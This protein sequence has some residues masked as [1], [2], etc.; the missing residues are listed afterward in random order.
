MAHHVHRFA[1]LGEPVLIIENW[2]Q[3]YEG[4]GNGHLSGRDRIEAAYTGATVERVWLT[5]SVVSYLRNRRD[6]GFARADGEARATQEAPEGTAALDQPAICAF[7]T[8]RIVCATAA[9]DVA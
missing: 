4:P 9:S 7:R 8:R 5:I 1:R 6:L 3:A 2:Y